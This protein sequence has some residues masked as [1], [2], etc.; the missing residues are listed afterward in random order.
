MQPYFFPYIG[1][2]QLINA[3]DLFVIYDD[4]NYI[5]GG[6][7]NRN[8]LLI[9]GKATFITA[10]LQHA[11]PHKRICDIAL[12]PETAWR[13]KLVRAVE[14]TYRRSPF[15]SETFP[16]IEEL[17]RHDTDNL[18]TY[19][20]H[21]LRTLAAFMGI[22]TEF[23]ISN[24]HYRNEALSGRA[25]VLDICKIEG[26][27]IYLNLPGGQSL[28][29]AETFRSHDLDLRFIAM[30]PMPYPQQASEFVPHLSIIDAL[31]GA[32][33]AAIRDHL[34]AFELITS[35]NKDAD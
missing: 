19:L 7:I 27:D 12:L 1:Y 29:D 15:F 23:A 4:V 16:V 31:M 20:A 5:K 11:S 6:W 14:N 9:N 8:R 26:A 18:A 10:P 13:D 35:E 25:R 22:D 28:Y 34:D 17:I 3:A 2:W 32:G 30:R 33:P 24:R 21:Q